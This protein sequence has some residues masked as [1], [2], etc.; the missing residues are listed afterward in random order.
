MSN[1][2]TSQDLSITYSNDTLFHD[3]AININKNDKIG[4]IGPNGSGKSTL[5]KILSGK[6]QPD[7]GTVQARKNAIIAYVPQSEV[8]PDHSVLQIVADELKDVMPDEHE[9]E[10][11]AYI[12]LG[13]AG[14]EDFEQT[15]ASLSGGWKKRLSIAKQL[16][17]DP[18]LLLLDEPTNHLDIQSIKWLQ[19]LLQQA[20]FAYIVITH[21]RY[22]L[23]E[24]S[25]YV[26]ELS[27]AYPQGTFTSKGN[28]SRFLKH[29]DEFLEAQ[30]KQQQSLENK[31][32]RDT[33]WLNQGIQGRQ[34]RNKTQ[35]ADAADRRAELQTINTRNNQNSAAQINFTATDRK[36]TKLIV[37][38]DLSKSF[39][40]N[41]LFS[42]LEIILGHGSRLGI[43]GDNGSGKSTIINI[44][45][46]QLE[47][48]TG[49]IKH[50]ENL[51]IVTFTQTRKQLD[52]K[53]TLQEA[54]C[55]VSDVVHFQGS[56]M[57][58]AAYAKMF[59]FEKE[60]FKTPV[61]DLSGGQQARILIAQL[62]L[63][64]ADLLILDEPTNDLDIPSLEVL[65]D[66]LKQFP[67]ALLLVTHDR[68]MLDRLCT[69]LLCL[70]GNGTAK[71]L[72][73][74]Q[75]WEKFQINQAK[76][77]KEQEK[78]RAQTAAAKEKI[79]E[80]AKAKN[81]PLNPTKKL[82]YKDQREFDNMEVNILQAEGKLET[83][84]EKSNDPA[85]I[86]DHGKAAQLFEAI[87]QAQ[88]EVA[89]LYARWEELEN[90][91]VTD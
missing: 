14:F 17:K 48:D 90:L 27:K 34:T 75:Q 50:A 47:S 78:K 4:M 19:Q 25:E 56:Q 57:H 76:A 16:V 33:A 44:I 18:D 30:V 39:G 68:F 8:Y 51:K 74:Y 60:Q 42:D 40:E 23:N 85:N 89:V 15:P 32:R 70:D 2:L 67:G 81:A 22:F 9:R 87:S 5:M 7:E 28:Y 82:S 59:L 21:D 69:D 36:T 52:P 13:K 41:K 91:Q 20:N 84:Q 45:T 55:P 66:S 53:I 88:H 26:I 38:E 37:G 3:V 61:G 12:T 31:I 77:A 73:D 24:I 79:E 6:I 64:K 58:V 65:E 1:L 63:K 10:T 29:K 80:K 46:K 54:L 11:Q 49:F 86:Q 72:A 71:Y 62:M 43:V 35:V 83:L